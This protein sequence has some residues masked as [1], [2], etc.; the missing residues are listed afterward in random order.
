[1][2]HKLSLLM[3]VVMVLFTASCSDDDDNV[4]PTVTNAL[5]LDDM[6]SNLITS[7]P[8]GDDLVWT[9]PALTSGLQMEVTISRDGQQYAR[10]TVS[11]T[12]C[13]QQ[14]LETNVEYTYVFRLT[15]GTNY[16]DGIVKKYTRAGASSIT[17]LTARQVEGTSGYEAAFSWDSNLDAT[18]YAVKV[19]DGTTTKTDTIT[20]AAY[21]VSNVA[22]DSNWDITVRA[23]NA[24]G[25]SLPSTTSVKIGKTAVA[26]LSYYATPED[27]IANGDDDEASAWLWFHEQY[28]NSR[29]LYAGS[30]TSAD[31]LSNLR[32]IFYI[33]DLNSGSENDVWT[34]PE[35]IQ[36][37][38]PYIQEWYKEGGNL[39]L[40]QHAVTYIT[41]LGRI[42]KKMLTSNDRRISIG[43]GNYNT[44]CW[45]MAVQINPAS[46]YCADFSQHPLY[47]GIGYISTSRTKLITVKGPCWT[48][49]HNCCFFNIPSA[50]TGMGNQLPETYDVLTKTYGIYPLG[51]WDSQIEW[52]SQLNVWEARQGNTDYKG[53][54]LCVGNGGLEF[55]HQNADGTADKSADPKN[56]PYQGTVL[57]IA[58]NAIEYLKTR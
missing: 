52:L 31:D 23:I 39:L 10:Q 18:S 6:R 12:S 20:T 26:F 51:T 29:Y 27:L 36:K 54:I 5:T 49:D 48:E 46:H 53:T 16:S 11:T 28:P 21:T 8:Q 56:N 38:T 3:L 43:N 45:Y 35:A 30:I 55:S 22:M 37:A 4:V 24:K 13:L 58:K 44:D 1:M 9:W 15:D 17:G 40:W 41:D 57:K 19:T 42:D 25:K 2:K 32:E 33:R 50:I 34:Q 47:K 7:Q 14:A